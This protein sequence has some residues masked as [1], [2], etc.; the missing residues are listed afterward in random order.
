MGP[1]TVVGRVETLDY[2][3]PD[4]LYADVASGVA[5]GTRI[6][7]PAGLHAQVNVTHRPS[8][9]YARNATATDAALTYSVRL[10]P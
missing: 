5:L 7:L 4:P 8:A 9:P 6:A 1:I 2:D 10:R 3:T